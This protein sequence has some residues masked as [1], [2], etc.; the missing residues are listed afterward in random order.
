MSSVIPKLV[1]SDSFDETE[2][3]IARI[4]ASYLRVGRS[5]DEELSS[6]KVI[7]FDWQETTDEMVRQA[8]FLNWIRQEH[9]DGYNI[10]KELFNDLGVPNEF[11]IAAPPGLNEVPNWFYGLYYVWYIGYTHGVSDGKKI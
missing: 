3:V 9:L 2:K 1:V 7:Y 8:L 5:T 10:F 6:E 4:M 11:G